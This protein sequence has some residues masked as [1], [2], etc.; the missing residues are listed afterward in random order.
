MQQHPSI[1]Q[2]LIVGLPG[3]TLDDSTRALLDRGVGGVILFSRNVDS[4]AQVAGLVGSI[5]AHA[6]RPI[7]VGVDQEGGRVARL[8]AGFTPLPTMRQLGACGEV[9]K[10]QAVGAVLGRE[11]AAVGIN[12]AFAPV[13]D[14]DTN[15]ANP[16]IGDR[17][18]GADPQVVAELGAAVARGIQS[19]GVAACGKHFPGHGDTTLDSHLALPRLPHDLHRLEAVELVPF[20]AAIAEGIASIMTSHIVFEAIDPDRPATVSPAVVTGLLRETLGYQGVVFSDCMQMKAIADTLGTVE[21]T[22]L[23]VRAGVDLVLISHDHAL[24]HAAID[25]LAAAGALDT[26]AWSASQ[27]RIDTLLSRYADPAPGAW[28]LEV[29]NS[30]EHRLVVERFGLNASGMTDPT[31][32]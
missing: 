26:D 9:G 27:Q 24:A 22:L 7:V 14:V 10:A 30:D 3:P 2:H 13:L 12:V 8:R 20:R 31:E 29:L 4:P 23:A 11:L 21:A 28:G 17:S 32:G 1:A 16:V 19:A 15:L 25:R 6:A 18:L 5:K